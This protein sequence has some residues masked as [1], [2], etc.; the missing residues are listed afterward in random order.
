[1]AVTFVLLSGR[2]PSFVPVWFAVSAALIVAYGCGES[3]VDGVDSINTADV[4]DPSDDLGAVDV[5]GDDAGAAPD[6]PTAADSGADAGANTTQTVSV[7][8][9][10]VGQ[11]YEYEA[12]TKNGSPAVQPVLDLSNLRPVADARLGN[13]RNIARTCHDRLSGTRGLC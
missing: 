2:R 13:H 6:T 7:P 10:D 4:G 3:P 9:V 11:V 8:G 1:M 12:L 5:G